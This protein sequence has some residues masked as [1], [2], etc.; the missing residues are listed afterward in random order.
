MNYEES[1]KYIQDASSRGSV[2]GLDNIVNLMNKLG[3]V[4]DS[5]KV[6]HIA[7]TNGKGSTSAY[8]TQILI[9]A[10][11]TVGRYTSPAVFDYMEMFTI[12]NINISEDEYAVNMTIIK[13]AIDEMKAEYM[14]LPTP[15]EIETALAYLYFYRNKCDIAII[16]TGMGGR[17]DATNIVK[18]P[19]VSV[20]TSISKDHSRFLGETLEEIA[21]NKA[22]IIKNNCPVV[23]AIQ[24]DEVTKV[25]KE[26]SIKNNSKLIVCDVLQ[27][28]R[29]NN[30]KTYG[31]Y[32]GISNEFNVETSMLG[33]F[34]IHNI[35]TAIETILV[36]KSEGFLILKENIENGIKNASISGRCER[37]NDTPAIYID[38]GHNP[39]AALNLKNTL[40][41]YFTNRKLVYI[42]GVLADK[43]YDTVLSVTG[44]FANHIITVTPPDNARSLD[45][46]ELL[47]TVLKYNTSAEY[48]DDLEKAV[49]RGIE[50]AGDDGVLFVFGSLSYL[51]RIKEIVRSKKG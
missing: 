51:G 21:F 12:N 36:L 48:A 34:Q 40:E 2:L 15:F 43:D 28:V 44:G 10:G 17:L 20:L 7:G 16:E 22:G 9:E 5:L 8:I 41:M 35:P 25:I 39:G 42:I 38:G 27:N 24:C 32:V 31:R 4:Q 19:L 47:K 37:I 13:K 14:T 11:Y 29:F 30:D 1:R 33:T 23:S 50:C 49:N 45:G 46:R 26:E 18:S 3:N 6:V